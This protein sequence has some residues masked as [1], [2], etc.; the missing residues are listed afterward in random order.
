MYSFLLVDDENYIRDAIAKLVDWQSLGISKIFQA[1]NG[2]EAIEILKQQQIDLV[3]TDIQMPG[4]DGLEL[5]KWISENSSNTTVAILTGHEEFEW[6]KQCLNYGV[7]KYILKPVGSLSLKNKMASIVKEMDL[8][9]IQKEQLAS[10]KQT[11]DVSMPILREKFLTKIICTPYGIQEDLINTME[12]LNLKIDFSNNA[13]AI[14]ENDNVEDVKDDKFMQNQIIRI[15]QMINNNHIIFSYE[16]RLIIMLININN[17]QSTKGRSE[18]AITSVL[19]YEINQIR[20]SLVENSNQSITVGIGAPCKKSKDLYYSFSQAKTVLDYRYTLGNNR[21]YDINDIKGFNKSF[22]YPEDL[23]N[24][25][26]HSIKFEDTDSIINALVA[27]N[28]DIIKE[29]AI[30]PENMKMACLELLTRIF[31]ELYSLT[32]I[33]PTFWNEGF[34]IYSKLQNAKTSSIAFE[35]INNFSITAAKQFSK[36][37][38]NFKQLC[39]ERTKEMV[40]K[41]YYD[42]S[43]SVSEIANQLNISTGYLSTVFKK[44]TG[45]SISKFISKTRIEKAMELLR[46]T[47]KMTYEIAEETGFD[48]S[49]YFSYAFKKVC[50]ISPTE[51]R[52]A[53]KDFVLNE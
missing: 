18:K 13:I 1:S 41:G 30:S 38:I 19:H 24:N 34:S 2:N 52:D 4:M 5:S 27:I 16:N 47:N 43:L 40:K 28:D 20:K 39:V 15:K 32:D 42:T 31:K 49:H 37:R 17:I 14:F 26:I 21:I 51:F 8:K 29:K 33:D 45:E 50:G 3:L 44:E 46:V 11:V 22:Y 7:K 12:F 6:A 23:I 10:L 36:T 53:R 9:R 48:N 35:L 25:I